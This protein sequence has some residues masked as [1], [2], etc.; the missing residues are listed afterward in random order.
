MFHQ[1][2]F[3]V[4]LPDHARYYQRMHTQPSERPRA[5]SVSASSCIM[6]R[7]VR[8]S[9]RPRASFAALGPHAPF[10]PVIIDGRFFPK[11]APD[12]SCIVGYKKKKSRRS[13][14]EERSAAY[15]RPFIRFYKSALGAVVAAVAG[16][17]VS[18]NIF[19]RWEWMM[20]GWMGVFK[21]VHVWAF[22]NQIRSINQSTHSEKFS[23]HT[24]TST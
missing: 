10:G 22:S 19:L 9:L 8:D 23:T 4:S 14:L 16:W 3:R 12:L 1:F 13:L 11:K 17:E 5:Q 20:A 15:A 6:R 2:H 18:I 24:D 7:R 21:T